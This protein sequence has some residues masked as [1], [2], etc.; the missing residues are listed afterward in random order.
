MAEASITV[1][2][3]PLFFKKPAKTSRDVLT[4]KPTWF[5]RIQTEDRVGIGECSII[6]GL[7]PEKIDD[8]DRL[9]NQLIMITNTDQLVLPDAHRFPAVRFA[10]EM[11]LKSLNSNDPMLLFHNDFT[12]VN[13]GIP[14]NGL[15][16]MN[17][18][19]AMMEQIKNRIDEG[20][21]VIKLKVG[22]LNF[23]EELNLIH[24]FRSEYGYHYELRLDANGAFTPSEALNKISRLAA[25]DIHSI[26]QPIGVKQW[27]EMRELVKHSD[28][29]I[30]LDEELI[31]VSD[32]QELLDQIEPQFIILKPSLLGGW[33]VCDNLITIANERSIDWWATSALESN[34]GLN[35][36]AQWC[37]SKELKLPQ[38]LGTG[39]LYTN[40]IQSPLVILNGELYYGLSNWTMPWE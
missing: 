1:Y 11:A 5:I 15:V 16:W 31:G 27:K 39:S 14:I 13:S 26:E 3:H 28:I 24:W 12:T 10:L 22:A 37:A 25:F 17:S 36:I 21:Q 20:F 9:L 6:P 18:I 38:G 30:A 4:K 35:A 19:P 7:N 40:N 33:S 29:P 2:S 23:E 34:I 32:Y 8:V